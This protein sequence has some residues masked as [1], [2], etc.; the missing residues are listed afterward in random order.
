[1]DCANRQQAVNSPIG[2]HI[3]SG[4]V[5]IERANHLNV[6][7]SGSPQYENKIA[8]D[9]DSRNFWH[10]H[11][12]VSAQTA[13]LEQLIQHARKSGTGAG[14]NSSSKFDQMQVMQSPYSHVQ[15]Q[16]YALG[17]QETLPNR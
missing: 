9:L 8:C 10:I 7:T 12:A 1:M 5:G 3:A 15:M 16:L 2:C 4:A 6:E 14:S 11:T 17:G 13:K